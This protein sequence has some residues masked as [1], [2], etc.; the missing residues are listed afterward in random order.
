MPQEH[1]EQND[2]LENEV[3]GLIPEIKEKGRQLENKQKERDQ[4]E[5]EKAQVTA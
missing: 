5:I 2:K 1:D 4:L 3:T